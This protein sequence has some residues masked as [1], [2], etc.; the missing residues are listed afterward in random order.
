MQSLNTLPAILD[1]YTDLNFVLSL[2]YSNVQKNHFF[3]LKINLVH[4]I[5]GCGV[6]LSYTHTNS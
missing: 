4:V 1:L 6:Y 3:P 5:I 2:A